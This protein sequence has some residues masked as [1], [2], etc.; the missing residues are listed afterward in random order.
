MQAQ[1]GRGERMDA[2]AIDA[3]TARIS[4]CR[5]SPEVLYAAPSTCARR[6]SFQVAFVDDLAPIDLPSTLA[7]DL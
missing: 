1:V 4:A 2:A 5:S 6:R 3:V 7:D